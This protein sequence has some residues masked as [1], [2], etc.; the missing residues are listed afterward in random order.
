MNIETID[1]EGFRQML[2]WLGI[3]VGAMA[4]IV[5]AD[6]WAKRQ[7]ERDAA[8]D[9]KHAKAMLDAR[10]GND[11]EQIADALRAHPVD[12][13]VFVAMADALEAG[14]IELDPVVLRFYWQRGLV[15][16]GWSPE[17][18]GEPP[19]LTSLGVAV[20]AILR[21]PVASA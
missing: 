10:F 2:G 5:L 3:A 15:L 7:A 8:R 9:L 4:V 20:A 19:R 18:P 12:A 11:P 17:N 16:M 13:S 1:P 6:L 21:T 14:E